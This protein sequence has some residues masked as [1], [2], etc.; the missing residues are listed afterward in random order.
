V[1]RGFLWDEKEVLDVALELITNSCPAAGHAAH[2]IRHSSCFCLSTPAPS[3]SGLRSSKL[4]IVVRKR[5][6]ITISVSPS[7]ARYT[8]NNK[9][10]ISIESVEAR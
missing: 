3:T 4:L 1:P 10:D 5:A 8:D 6:A 2:G 7:A 9:Q